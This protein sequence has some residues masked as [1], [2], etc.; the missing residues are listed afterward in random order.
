MEALRSFT[1]WVYGVPMLMLVVWSGVRLT[2][3]CRCIQ[4]RRFGDILRVP[5]TR[6]KNSAT[7]QLTPF[8]AMSM[9]IG[10]SVGV[11][12]ISG[13]ST[14]IVT[15]GAG[16]LFW[17]LVSA[18]LGMVIKMAEVTLACFYRHRDPSGKLWG[19]PTYYIQ[20]FLGQERGKKYWKIPALLFGG[21]IFVSFFINV[22]NYSV[23]EAIGTT[24]DLPYMLPSVVLGIVTCIMVSGGLKK[25][26]TL[27]SYLVPFMCLF[28]IGCTLVVLCKC[29]DNIIPSLR[30]IVSNA[31]SLRPAVG[32]VAGSCMAV[33]LRTGF[34]RALYSNEAGWGTSPMVHAA[35]ECS[36][37]VRQGMLGAFEVFADTALV[38]TATGMLVICTGA[39]ESGLMGAELTLSALQ[40]CLGEPARIAVALSV[41][42]FG[43]TSALGWY[44]YYLTLMHHGL[45]ETKTRRLL[46]LF[47]LLMPAMGVALTYA[48]VRFD[49]KPDKIWVIAD[50]SAI[51]PTAINLIMLL[52]M[53]PQ[54][55][56]LV[57]DWES[58]RTE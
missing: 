32:G 51:F 53:C 40:T 56:Q 30:L 26:G 31:F 7:G 46:P 23:A 5:F 42:L 20:R 4:L 1:H 41:F 28:Y 16:A 15:G 19:G 52:M 25:L 21:G 18:F 37:P 39:Y 48:A 57:K 58:K 50:F 34:A 9:A 10:G 6:D 49:L 13:V 54:F 44:A 29:R 35:A 17:M 55:S 45:G 12:N 38:C 14:A 27:C 3:A 43:L 47:N 36:H 33:S 11:A 22:Q 2:I 8:Q 24:F